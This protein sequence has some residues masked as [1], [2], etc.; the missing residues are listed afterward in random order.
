VAIIPREAA[1]LP[2][3][4]PCCPTPDAATQKP[5]GLCGRPTCKSCRGFVN[6]RLACRACLG[7]VQR[8]LA[9][10]RGGASSIPGGVVG[11]AV[12]ALVGGGAWALIA[13]LTSLAIGYVAVGV[14]F[15][16]GYGVLVGAGRKKSAQLQGVAVACALLGLLL[17]KYF[18]VAHFLIEKFPDAGLSYLDSR[19]FK[20]FADH[21][22]DFFRP[23][24]L[25][26][27]F[28]ALGAAVRVTR[29]TQAH[30]RAPRA[31]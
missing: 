24:D 13:I 14:G 2:L 1:P 25:L 4:A 23:F 12:G 9:A 21:V 3:S 6:S 10:E 19:L 17:G 20:I 27:M 26:W 31:G 22:T 18:I 7:Q 15:L 5:C 8:E 16:A 11:G 30:V 28:L 29:P